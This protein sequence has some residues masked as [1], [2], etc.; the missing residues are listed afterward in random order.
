MG[1]TVGTEQPQG[2]VSQSNLMGP[3][4]VLCIPRGLRDGQ[5]QS[6][7]RGLPKACSPHGVPYNTRGL[8]DGAD[9]DIRDIAT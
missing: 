3:H 9:I 4:D 7:V 8:R 6:H 5:G 2:M 1:L